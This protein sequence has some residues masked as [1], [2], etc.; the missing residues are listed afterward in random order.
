MDIK[1]EYERIKKL[2]EGCDDSQLALLEGSFWECARLR[3][4]L[5]DL[6]D[7]VKETGLVKINPNNPTQQKE[8]PVSKLIVKTRANYLN[9]I[10]KLSNILGKSIIEE[11]DDLADYE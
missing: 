3:V 7:I 11:D 9:Y 8:L 4:E 5:D 2:F 1:Q 10:A 6:H